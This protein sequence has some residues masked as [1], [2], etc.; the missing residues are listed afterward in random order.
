MRLLDELIIIFLVERNLNPKAACLKRREEEKAEDGPKLGPGPHHMI[1]AP[2]Y[3]TIPVSV[4]MCFIPSRGNGRR[5]LT[6]YKA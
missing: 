3:P 2:H 6:Q 5:V 1:P 4:I